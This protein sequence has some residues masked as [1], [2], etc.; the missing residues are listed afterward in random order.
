MGPS[1]AHGLT[2]APASVIPGT[3]YRIVRLIGH[4]G[5]GEVYEVEHQLLGTHRALKMLARDY[6]GR[7]DFAERLRVEARGL[8]RLKHPNLVEVYDL[9]TSDDGRIFFVMELLV[10]MTLRQMLR[11]HRALGPEWAVRLIG[12]VL[13]G[14]HAAHCA[15]IIHRDIKPE[16]VFVCE[17]GRVKLLDFGVAK[18]IAAWMPDPQLTD[19][20]TT[21]GTPRYMAPEQAKGLAVDAR[22]DVYAAGLLLWECLSGCPAFT[23]DDPVA[24]TRRK[25]SVGVPA[26]AASVAGAV[27]EMLRVA[28]QRATHMD[29]ALRYPTAEAF[30]ADIRNALHLGRCIPAGT[31]LDDSMETAPTALDTRAALTTPAWPQAASSD[32]VP[33]KQGWQPAEPGSLPHSERPSERAL[34]PIDREAPTRVHPVNSERGP[35]GTQLLPATA[36]SRLHQA[37][38]QSARTVRLDLDPEPEDDAASTSSAGG[39]AVSTNRAKRPWIPWVLGA[40]VFGAPV[41]GAL[42]FAIAYLRAS[43][44]PSGHDAAAAPAPAASA[45]GT[46]TLR[47][48]SPA[49]AAFVSAIA[50]ASASASGSGAG[51]VPVPP[52]PSSAMAP[53]ATQPGRAMPA[54][55]L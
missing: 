25:T 31:A 32:T 33:E 39:M 11:Q 26:L 1:H 12:Q 23:E 18:A 52:V 8:A 47:S 24:L 19:V 5:M 30:A 9:G 53:T 37:A 6:Q 50:S 14:L 41:L 28:L 46:G 3:P 34:G 42:I 54:P 40:A 13:D 55:G 49:A 4:G 44:S 51:R 45:S 27:P 16:N 20:G 2:W 43:P 7:G 17:N 22:T 21:V 36:A 29:P 38:V 35:G 15:G 48:E 10:G